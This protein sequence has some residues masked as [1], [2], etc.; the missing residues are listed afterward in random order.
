M[1]KEYLNFDIHLSPLGRKRYRLTVS[2]PGGDASDILK[3]ST[4]SLTYHQDIALLERLETDLDSLL[5]LGQSLFHML[6]QGEIKAVYARSQGVL[7]SHQGLRLRFTIDPKEYEAAA[8][9]WEF[10]IDPDQGP[11]VMLDAPI[12]RY[13]PQQAVIPALVAPLPLRV[14]VTSSSA[15]VSDQGIQHEFEEIQHALIGLSSAVQIETEP[16]LTRK[17]L[18]RRLREG[19]HIWHFIGQGGVTK[20]GKEAM[21]LFESPTGGSEQVSALEL[22]ILLRGSDLRLVVLDACDRARLLI[23][24]FRSIAPA[25]IRA[26]IPAV[27]AMQ[28]PIPQQATQAFAGEFYRALAEGFPIDACVTEGRKAV[29]SAT[30]LGRPDWGIPV[31]YTRAS[32]GKLFEI[33]SRSTAGVEAKTS[34]DGVPMHHIGLAEVLAVADQNSAEVEW[35]NV[36]L[37]L[38]PRILINPFGKV[39]RITDPADFFGRE[40]LLRQIFEELDKGSNRSI[41]GASQV[42][43]SSLLSMV[44]ALGPDRLK[45]PPSAFVYLDMQGIHD[46]NDFFE[47]L[48]D[49]LGIPTCRGSRLV[50]ALRGK[51]YV[52]CLDE[53]EKMTKDRFTGDERGELRGL[54]DGTDAPL[55]LLIASRLPLDR[56]FPDSMGKT[57]PLANIC[58]QIE[59][60][61]FAPEVARTFILQRLKGTGIVF[62]S[63]EIDGLVAQSNGVPAHLQQAAAELFD[64]YR[65]VAT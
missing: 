21:L 9:P 42:G 45:L 18:M 4:S 25:L 7:N 63:V 40:E 46:E 1:F 27:V 52:V 5:R 59:V 31:V 50:R 56:L 60:L 64:R 53:V 22:G 41:V 62:T 20:D 14:L 58:P 17:Q 35:H 33:S 12:V 47:A 48:C 32:D 28:F 19:F 10:L 11:L 24:P 57:S 3:L 30:G 51:R 65:T 36:H 34:D 26:Q 29:M 6:F 16:H 13:L 38:S 39:G 44:C 49:A 55:K 54:A 15:L 23:E 8:M 61:P 37:S 43:K 2:S